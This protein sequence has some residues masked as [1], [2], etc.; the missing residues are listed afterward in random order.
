MFT[1]KKAFGQPKADSKVV[2]GE[3]YSSQLISHVPDIVISQ[4]LQQKLPHAHQMFGVLMFVDVSGFTALCEKYSADPKKGADALTKTL[5]EYIGAIVEN[6]LDFEGDVIKFAGD[7]ILAFWETSVKTVLHG[8]AS[9]VRC[10]LNIQDKCDD[11]DTEVG[12]QLRVKIGIAA[13]PLFITFLGNQET[14]QFVMSGSCIENVRNAEGAASPGLVVLSP[15]AWKVLPDKELAKFA[16]MEDSK[17]V[18]IIRTDKEWAKVFGVRPSKEKTK[19]S[20]KKSGKFNASL[21]RKRQNISTVVRKGMLEPYIA[22]PVMHKIEEQQPLEYLCELR[23]VSIVFINLTLDNV[24]KEEECFILQDTF[25]AILETVNQFQGSLNKIFMF[26]KGCTFLVIFGLPGYKHENECAHALQCSHRIRE[27]LGKVRKVTRASVG[28]TTGNV[29]TGVVGHPDRCEYT[30]IGRKVNMAARLMMHYP[31]LIATDDETYRLSK[32]G[33]YCFKQLP[34]KEMKGV[35]QAGI[36]RHYLENQRAS[37]HG[38]NIVDSGHPLLGYGDE[39]SQFSSAL[40]LITDHRER[41]HRRFVIFEGEPGV[42]KTRVLMSATDEAIQRRHKVISC[43]LWMNDSGTPYYTIKRLLLILFHMD[44]CTNHLQ[45]EEVLFNA[46]DA[47]AEG[48]RDNLCLLND[49]LGLQIPYGEQFAHMSTSKRDMELK[50]LLVKLVH[51]VTTKHC[52]IFAIDDAHFIDNESWELLGDLAADS[53]AVCVMT[54]RPFPPNMKPCK[55]AL[56]ILNNN[57]TMHIKLCGLEPQYMEPLACQF[58]DVVKVPLDLIK[59]LETRSHGL[60]SWVEALVSELKAT[61]KLKI[62]PDPTS[63]D[64]SQYICIVTPKVKLNELPVPDSLKGML[65]AKVDRLNAGDRMVV[66]CA[67]VIGMSMGRDLL[68]KVVP[69]SNAKKVMASINNLVRANLM[70]YVD[71]ESDQNTLRFRTG[72]MQECAYSLLTES[73]RKKLHGRVATFLEECYLKDKQE[74]KSFINKFKMGFMSSKTDLERSESKSSEKSETGK[75]ES[76]LTTVYPQLVRHW[77]AAGNKAKTLQYLIKVGSIAITTGHNMQA[78][79]YLAQ[80]K[81]LNPS[82]EQQAFIDD[83]L[84]LAL[85]WSLRTFSDSTKGRQTKW[86]GAVRKLVR[87]SKAELA[88]KQ[89]ETSEKSSED[90]FTEYTYYDH[91]GNVAYVKGGRW[92]RRLLVTIL[93][94]LIVFGIAGAIHMYHLD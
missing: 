82:T 2:K 4:G 57:F 90:S 16:L 61:D 51:Q 27:R 37:Q 24:P 22:T 33:D 1:Q 46:V 11:W 38:L 14:Q 72:L 10:G 8:L 15:K 17:H 36:I 60:P 74:D 73:Q 18:K 28:V 76:D 68:L 83:L 44:N 25:N 26:D 84:G 78:M 65:L 20:K 71:Y 35:K 6:V 31:G 70:D 42:G 58:L 48:V 77:R 5:N 50:N 21:P 56:D 87:G 3:D 66:K 94:G 59:I 86:R 34:I 41:S 79:S 53:N 54:M 81:N 45:R 85:N 12:V 62:I 39:M 67:A 40:R 30:V 63:M 80:A 88:M 19:L 89:T 32:L 47:A 9:A 52:L 91:Q 92:R 43:P 29:F 49:L 69:N 7:A 23:Q 55:A 64:R 93:F 75:D 13:G